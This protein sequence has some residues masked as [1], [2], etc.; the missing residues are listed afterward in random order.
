M[1]DILF[2][3]GPKGLHGVDRIDDDIVSIFMEPNLYTRKAVVIW[4]T[5]Q[6]LEKPQPSN[7]ILDILLNGPVR[8]FPELQSLKQKNPKILLDWLVT[9][10]IVRLW[11]LIATPTGGQNL[12]IIVDPKVNPALHHWVKLISQCDK[13]S[14]PPIKHYDSESLGCGVLN[15][16]KS[17]PYAFRPCTNPIQ[18]ITDFIPLSEGILPQKRSFLN[19][20]SWFVP[21]WAHTPAPNPWDSVVV[22]T[23]MR[24]SY[25]VTDSFFRPCAILH[26]CDFGYML[27]IPPP[28]EIGEFIDG[29]KSGEPG[30]G[31]KDSQEE[32]DLNKAPNNSDAQ[33]PPHP[34]ES[35]A[36]QKPTTAKPRTGD[37]SH[38]LAMLTELVGEKIDNP[39]KAAVAIKGLES[40]LE[41][42]NQTE[43]EAMR[44]M[45][46]KLR[47]LE[48]REL[49]FYLLSYE[50]SQKKISKKTGC[51][52]GTVNR[53]LKAVRKKGFAPVK[54]TGGGGAHTGMAFKKNRTTMGIPV[55]NDSGEKYDQ[56]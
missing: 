19:F 24:R 12:L 46:F 49:Q 11:M 2:I 9:E 21:S 10:T 25:P 5:P 43:E 20:F 6:Y 42:A 44:L 15:A 41:L 16:V 7:Q 38:Y 17:W 32:S 40:R 51:S 13:I 37:D 26:E 22:D 35:D 50:L 34:D 36:P 39:D 48:P 3:G 18:K 33:E 47:D 31:P 23:E 30:A 52:V 53:V 55:I 45:L 56:Y 1:E 8:L 29:L 54:H 14:E 27:V 28:K 4:P